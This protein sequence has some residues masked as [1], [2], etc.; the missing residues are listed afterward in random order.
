[1]LE[2]AIIVTACHHSVV[3]ST[4]RLVVCVCVCVCVLRALAYVCM[5]A[6]HV[7]ALHGTCVENVC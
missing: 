7:H 6:N 5:A 4:T 2:H 3:Q 1:M